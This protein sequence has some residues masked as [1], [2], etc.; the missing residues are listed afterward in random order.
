MEHDL[1]LFSPILEIVDRTIHTQF[2]PGNIG[3][4]DPYVN[5]ILEI[6]DRTIQYLLMILK[7]FFNGGP[8]GRMPCCC[9]SS[10]YA[11][12]CFATSQQFPFRLKMRKG[13]GQWSRERVVRRTTALKLIHFHNNLEKFAFSKK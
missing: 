3:S 12:F 11:D 10:S 8:G 4:Y 6:V 7:T 2:Y 9:H 1:E 5:P 13:L